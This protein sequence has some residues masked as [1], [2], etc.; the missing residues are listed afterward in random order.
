MM[1]NEQV[2][3]PYPIGVPP[4]GMQMPSEK[5]DILDKI[6]PDAIVET[7]MHRLMGEEKINGVWKAQKEVKT[8]ALNFQG[9]WDIANLMLSASSQNV[10]ISKVSDA[11]IRRRTE[12]IVETALIMCQRN[13]R[14][15]GITGSDQIYFVKEI[16]LTNTFFTLKQPENGGIQ[17]LIKGTTHDQRVITNQEKGGGILN[18]IIR[19]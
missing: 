4:M 11:D 14:E 8:R 2:E 18:S 9:A 13:W 10:S 19:R 6:K 1:Q 15:Y 17:N 16:V 5:A 12:S 7:L 3:I